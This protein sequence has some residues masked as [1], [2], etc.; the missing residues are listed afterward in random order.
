MLWNFICLKNYISEFEDNS[1]QRK[2]LEIMHDTFTNSLIK[3]S[4]KVFG[5]II[6]PCFPICH[7]LPFYPWGV[8]ILC[9][10]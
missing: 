4:V 2:T 10:L 8:T 3:L 6:Y 7:T 1:E 9:Y 5:A